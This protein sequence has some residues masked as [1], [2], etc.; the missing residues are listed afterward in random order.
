MLCFLFCFF[1][2]E[3]TDFFI[4]MLLQVRKDHTNSVIKFQLF[5]FDQTH[6]FNQLKLETYQAHIQAKL[7]SDVSKM[8]HIILYQT[9]IL[10]PMII[11]IKSTIKSTMQI[12]RN[13]YVEGNLFK[14]YYQFHYVH[15]IY[16]WVSSR[17]FV[18][19][20]SSGGFAKKNCPNV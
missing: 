9:R 16:V 12:N 6:C 13:C 14:W 20:P 8:Q 18:F 1:T 15:S 17:F 4:I 7:L 2:L 19:L 11:Y 10:F 5:Y 3:C